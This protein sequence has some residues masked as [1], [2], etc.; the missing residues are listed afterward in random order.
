SA[1][2][3][4]GAQFSELNGVTCTA[5][6]SCVAVG[7]YVTSSGANVTL[8]ERWNGSTWAIQPTPNPS[9][10]QSFSFLGDISCIAPAACE[11]VGLSDA[12][13]FAE[14]WNGTSWSVQAV[15]APAG[16]QFAVLPSVS[17]AVSSCE[18]VGLYAD[19]SG[20]VVTL[21][22]RWNGTAWHAQPT[23][24]P[25]RANYNFLTGISCPSLSDCTA[26]GWGNASGTPI[27]LGERWQGGRWSLQAVPSPVGAA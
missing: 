11:A 10:A 7:D 17:C 18:A 27:T 16:A 4:H 25:A 8:A 23:P 6:A 3:P 12:G 9:T 5:A 13:I 1:P 15:R 20:A 19:S 21:G 22:E 2:V 14:R 24:N 26:V